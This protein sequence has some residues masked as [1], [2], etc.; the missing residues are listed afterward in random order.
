V[1]RQPQA[2]VLPSVLQA[3]EFRILGPLEVRDGARTI[4]LAGGRQR[5]LLALLILNANERVSID[6]LV[7]ELWDEQSPPTAPKVIQNL[8]SQLRR[9]LGDGL[10]LTRGSGYVLRLEPDTVDVNRF[11]ELL[12]EGRRTLRR[13]DAE[14]AGNLLRRALD[15]WRGPPLGELGFESFAQTEIAHLEERRVTALEERI[16]ADLALGRHDDLI[17]ELEA[18]IATHPLRERLR[19]QLM[20]ALYRSGRQSEALNAYQDARRTLVEEVGIEP[21]RQLRELHRAILQQERALELAPVVRPDAEAPRGAF[22]GRKAELAKLV[23][24]LDDAYAGRGRLFLLVGEPGIGKSRLAEELLGQARARGARTLIGRCWEAGGAPAYWPWVQSFRAYVRE[25]D[26]DELG[27]QLASG[28]ADLAQI[29]P[30]LREQHPELPMP[31]L[32]A[33]GARFRLF[34]AASRFLREAAAARPIVLVLDDLHAADEPSLLLLQFVAGELGNS[35]LLIVGT[36]R[37]VDPTVRD[38]LASTLAELAREPATDRIELGGL[39]EPDVGRYIEVTARTTAPTALTAAI[40]SETQGNPLFVGEVVRLLSG[41]GRL[42]ADDLDA[43]WSLGIPQGV[44]EVIV[45]RLRR[46]SAECMRVLTLASVLGR[47]FELG[48]L[49]QLAESCGDDLLD[50]LDE[51]FAERVL[52]AVPGAPGRLRFAHALIRETLYDQLTTPRRVQ[53]HRRAGKALEALYAED[54]DPHLAELAYHFFEAAPGGDREKALDYTTRAGKRA[55]ALLAYEEGARFFDLALQALDLGQRVEPETRCGL[56]LSLGDAL[57]RAG[58]TPEAQETFLA[59]AE[60]ARTAGLPEQL[61]R[62]ALGYGG[63][64]PY[65]RAG[66]DKRLVP[67]LEEALA[68]LGEQQSV[69]RVRVLARLAGALRDQPSLEPRSSLSGEAVELA[70]TLGDKDALGYALVSLFMASWSPDAERLRAIAQQID[71]LADETGDIALAVQV[72]AR[73][74]DFIASLTLGETQRVTAIVEKHR[75]LADALKQP[76]LQW[77][78]AV[79]RSVWVLFHGDFSEAEKVAEEAQEL[80][81]RAQR[82]DAG[83]SYRMVL[84]VLRREQG[85]LEEVEELIRRSIDEYPGYRSF[86]CLAALIDCELGREHDA[87][88]AFDELA[89]EDF[90]ALPADGEWL[91]CFCILSEVA[92]HLQDDQRAAVLYRLLLP[93][94]RLNALAAGEVAIGSVSRYLGVLASATGRW[95]DAARHFE[96]GLELNAKMGARP[97]LAHTEYDYARM[98][99]RRDRSGDSERAVELLEASKTLAEE[100]GMSALAEKIPA[101]ATKTA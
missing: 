80:G 100:L 78:N 83:F 6:R 77:H 62:A 14:E 89:A 63:R 15:L 97:W 37:D 36:Y 91:F 52:A 88:Q 84:F 81:Q 98:L 8:V 48:A 95:D 46:L 43:L 94:A 30:E 61:A 72:Q 101:L 19:A 55:V 93:H 12:A 23:T 25:T 11:E 38:P 67:L 2:T 41:E 45:R 20:L 13:G 34:D 54:P 79:I 16:E 86:P 57:A 50:V 64:F 21:G 59:T 65:A 99:L 40:H 28:A 39:T 87:R 47:E 7:E 32:E 58:N 49:E 53:L 26:D 31:S 22:V 71:R 17:G 66:L 56:L 27:S 73:M 4:P 70:R 5:A 24:G 82:W 1:V 75:A 29:V 76:A 92:A 90:S 10:L 9:A 3:M 42:A 18:L 60:I 69:L 74:V 68:A 51:A 33:E 96:D 85:R 35:R 44:R